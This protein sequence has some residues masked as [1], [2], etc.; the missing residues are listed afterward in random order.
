MRIYVDGRPSLTG[1]IES[2]LP[3]MVA[4]GAEVVY[5]YAYRVAIDSRAGR[6]LTN[7]LWMP[8]TSLADPSEVD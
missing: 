3:S 7:H 1:L 6:G 5:E 8:E 2:V 4:V